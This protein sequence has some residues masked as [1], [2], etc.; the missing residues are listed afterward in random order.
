MKKL[1]SR[2]FL[3]SFLWILFWLE[4]V[5]FN[6]L[7]WQRPI[8]LKT[9]L[10]IVKN[11][12]R[13]KTQ[14]CNE[15]FQFLFS[16]FIFHVETKTSVNEANSS[17]LTTIPCVCKCVCVCGGRKFRGEYD[18]QRVRLRFVPANWFREENEIWGNRFWW[19]TFSGGNQ[20][21]RA[22]ANVDRKNEFWWCM[23]CRYRRECICSAYR[24]S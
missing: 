9:L 17:Y 16:K 13:T 18:W 12:K 2:I 3:K 7:S 21:R 10:E 19:R 8:A 5:I 20:I 4:A 22:K 24:N 11:S 23:N 1:V 6:Y 14:I 15:C